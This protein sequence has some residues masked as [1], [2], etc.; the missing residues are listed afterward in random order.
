[1]NLQ[2]QRLSSRMRDRTATTPERELSNLLNAW[3]AQ[4]QQMPALEERF[5]AAAQAIIDSLP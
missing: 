4:P 2:V 3:F 1:M 5:T